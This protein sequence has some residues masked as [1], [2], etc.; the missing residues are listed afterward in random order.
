MTASPINFL[1]S[2]S[3]TCGF[4]RWSLRFISVLPKRQTFRFPSAVN[5]RRLQVPQKLSLI[6]VMKPTLPTKPGT[7]HA[8]E[9]SFEAS[10]SEYL[11]KSL[12]FTSKC[13]CWIFLGILLRFFLI[14]FSCVFQDVISITF[15]GWYFILNFLDI[16]WV[17]QIFFAKIFYGFFKDFG[18]LCTLYHISHGF[19][20]LDFFHTK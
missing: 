9:V 10:I 2:S 12:I 11:K 20:S 3:D 16:F 19:F 17:F 5:L 6:E 7:F 8:L 1:M 4:R 13:F 18:I 14:F 15:F